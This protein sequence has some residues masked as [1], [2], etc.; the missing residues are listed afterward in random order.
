MSIKETAIKLTDAKIAFFTGYMD[1]EPH[2]TKGE[3][4][5]KTTK[6]E[7]P[8]KTLYKSSR[9]DVMPSHT[10]IKA[11]D[12]KPTN[13]TNDHNT[14]VLITGERSNNIILIDWDLQEW[15]VDSQSFEFN[16]SIVEIYNNIKN[17]IFGDDEPNTYTEMTGNGGI[18]WLFKYDPVKL[19]GIICERNGFKINN[20]KCGDI[21]GNG[22]LC[23]LAPSSYKS[24]DG[25]MKSYEVETF[26]DF[27]KIAMMPEILFKHIDFNIKPINFVKEPKIT[28]VKVVE[29]DSDSGNSSSLDDNDNEDVNVLSIITKIDT[30]AD[31]VH[32]YLNCIDANDYN[33]FMNVCFTF[34]T[35]P[36]YHDITHQWARQSTKYNKQETNA[37]LTKANGQK[38][39]ASICYMA[40]QNPE[41]YKAIFGAIYDKEKELLNMIDNFNDK[42][43]AEFY[44]KYT[45]YEHYYDESTEQWFSLDER[46]VWCMSTKIPEASKLKI[47]RFIESRLTE[48]R[49]FILNKKMQCADDDERK[50]IG[51]PSFCMIPKYILKIGGIPFIKNVIDSLKGFYINKGITDILISQDTNRYK[52]AFD[53]CLFDLKT[54]EIRP[55]NPEDYIIITTGYDYD[56]KPKKIDEVNKILTDIMEPKKIEGKEQEEAVENS[57]LYISDLQH[58]KNMFSSMLC[59]YNLKRKFNILAGKG[60]NG[61]SLMIDNLVKPAF[62]KYYASISPTYFTKADHNSNSATPELA[63]KQYVRALCLSEPEVNEKFQSSKIKKQTG[64]DEVQTRQLYSTGRTWK[65]QYTPLCLCNDIPEL[66]ST[67][68][69]TLERF[70]IKYLYNKFVINPDANNK[71]QRPMIDD[72]PVIMN[73]DAEYKKSFIWILIE[74]YKLMDNNKIS[75]NSKNE[76]EKYVKANNSIYDYIQESIEIVTGESIQ[77]N[78]V[79]ANY[80]AY[81]FVNNINKISSIAF[82]KLMKFND[83]TQ[84]TSR[85]NKTFWKDIKLKE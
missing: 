54:K 48:Y 26:I 55:I 22:G 41:K 69:A 36:K 6:G 79:Y 3:K 60:C 12:W 66:A 40:R 14:I 71:F 27:D 57:N 17:L 20:I 39:I 30:E 15:N 32:G 53:N 34:G 21:K 76:G 25:Y 56:D 24:L 51:G 8:K 18:H 10:K 67:D 4:P 65:P 64:M 5:K 81:C 58:I 38:T 35:M 61:K 78:E 62:G 84:Q 43:I 45:K 72:L 1:E 63:D 74:N 33:N 23:Y 46:K 2:I 73:N 85:T 49:K 9:K 80:T 82:S 77:C 50:K 29:S 52:F 31:F 28:I 7:K 68:I 44:Y 83:F 37:F 70:N 47:Q 11:E 42:N 19:N 59:G 13:I 75:L 16:N